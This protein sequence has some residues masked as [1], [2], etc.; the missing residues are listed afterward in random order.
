MTR[1]WH[2]RLPL[3]RL[4]AELAGD[5]IGPDDGEYEEARRV[6]F[7]L[8]DRRPAA[9]VRPVDADEVGQVVA[10]AAETGLELAVR[11]GGHS[12]A[13]HGVVEDGIVL[14]LG[15][16]KQLEIDPDERIVR[17]GSGL[18]TGEVT[19]AT[20]RYDLAVGFGDTSSVGIA[21]LTLGGGVG[22]LVRKHG[23]TIDSLLAAEIVLADGTLVRADAERHPDL[24]WA[25]RG[26]GGNFGVATRFEYRLRP[27]ESATGGML[28]LP[29][30]A[31][32]IVEFV[33][34]A[35]EAPIELSTI[36]GVMTAPPLPFVPAEHH[37]RPVILATMLHAGP[38]DDGER[39]VAPFRGL[40][41][42]IVDQL[43]PMPYPE[44]FPPANGHGGPL[45][46]VR[47]LFVDAVDRSA[48][49]EL[50]RRIDASSALV[51]AV[52]LRVLGGA[53]A[54]VP[55]DATAFA[56]RRRRIMVNVGAVFATPDEA[57]VHEAWAAATAD[58]L[59]DGGAGAYVNFLGDEGADRV[60][61]AYPGATWDRLRA[62]KRRYDPD[63]LFRLNQN[64][65]P[66]AAGAAENRRAAA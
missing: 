61:A 34:A 15:R 11:G 22:Y 1:T 13:G 38:L 45:A 29:A 12:A 59:R 60:R 51:A 47:T 32:T 52:Q 65:P 24:F 66:A 63:N 9:I 44:I 43:R 10:F 55:D 36:A 25:I 57:P 58:A 49:L 54:R 42:P 20:A 6:F 19:S 14:D 28:I 50:L 4:R 5:V 3:Q 64:I 7:P 56:H 40:A 2:A 26:G 33:A 35:D 39:A 8:F 41:E 53:V 62:V 18:S 16:L 27:L 23:L 46:T 48:A 17:A 31:E 37:G 30:T 21:G